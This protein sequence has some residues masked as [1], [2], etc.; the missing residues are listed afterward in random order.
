MP[1]SPVGF[2]FIEQF[3]LV[4]QIILQRKNKRKIK[5]CLYI[6]NMTGSNFQKI[7]QFLLC[8]IIDLTAQFHPDGI[9]TDTF[10][11]SCSIISR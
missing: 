3:F 11:I 7:R 9:Q 1:E 2:S 10:L 8:F 5:R 4:T 6:N